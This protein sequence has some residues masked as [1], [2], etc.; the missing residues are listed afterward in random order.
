MTRLGNGTGPSPRFR[1]GTAAAAAASIA[2]QV[3]E[4]AEV[5][6]GSPSCPESHA[7]CCT[8]EGEGILESEPYR[9]SIPGFVTKL[10]RYASCNFF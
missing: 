5:G 1:R 4:E 6:G 10:Y 8:A 7:E 3:R 9:K 2:S